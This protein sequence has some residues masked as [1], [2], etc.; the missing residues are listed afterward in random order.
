[1]DR[2]AFLK[3][4]GVTAGALTFAGGFSK[5]VT[6]ADAS[7]G[8]DIVV[9]NMLD[10][11]SIPKFVNQFIV[12]PVFVPRSSG[13]FEIDASRLSQQ[14]LP[15]KDANGHRTGF[16]PT[17]VFAYDGLVN[18]PITGKRV[19]FQFTPAGTFDVV[20]G[21]PTK[22]RWT[23]SLTGAHFLPVDPT[24][25]WA[26]PNGIPKPTSNFPPFPPGYPKAQSPIP[27][28]THLHG[29]EVPS[30]YDGGPDA[31]FTNSGLTGPTYSTQTYNYPND[32]EA[33]TLFYHD[34]ALGMTRL[35]VYAGLAGFYLIRDPCDK[36]EPLLPSGKYE[37]PIAIQ[38]RMFFEKDS[39]G[40]NDLAFPY[41]GDVPDVHPY[42]QPEF[43]GNT[44]M[45]NGQIWPNANVDRGQYRLRFVNGSNARF[46]TMA[47]S[48]GMSFTQIGSDGGYL[49]KPAILTQLTLAPGERADILVDFSNSAP[50]TK[51]VLTNSAPT[52]FPV[53]T[54]PDA[55][56][57]QIMQFTVGKD[58]GFKAKKLPSTLNP[59]LAGSSFPTLPLSTV[60]KN[61]ILTLTELLDMN[62]GL[63]LGLFLNGSMWD[64]PITELPK[65]G[66][67]EDWVFAN[68]TGDTHPMHLHLIQ[69]Q[70]VSR[71]DFD[72][73][74]YTTA[75]LNLNS[76]GLM[77]GMLPFNMNYKPKPLDPTPYLVPGTKTAALPSEM[78]WKDVIQTNPHQVTTIRARFKKQDGM[79]FGFDATSGPGYVWH[80]HIIDHEDNEMMRPYKLVK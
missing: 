58:K 8:G 72:D 30:I 29:G 19:H 50:G 25:H 7:C 35:N 56:T 28:V 2:R 23:N 70:L 73:A 54:A 40:N 65:V 27:M 39:C 53:G 38:D 52:P 59:T 26:N 48:N 42:W 71:Q 33:T 16:G 5:L 57:G 60:S 22:V 15:V 12:P 63:S 18:D 78:G 55:N 41:V 11:N 31:W 69:F 61:R 47:F 45:V 6:T 44:I 77:N 75:W 64:A 17:N 32:Q 79:P 1:M 9:P 34:H 37:L 14:I 51:I 3:M 62:S 13:L 24:L 36:I 21:V 67:T 10:P 76:A 74:A 68:L 49:Q 80:C 20:K 4:A 43:F 46:Y 66:S